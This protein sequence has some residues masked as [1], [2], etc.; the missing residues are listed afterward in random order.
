[1]TSLL[2]YK[3]H[4]IRELIHLI[5]PE[6]CLVCE[7]ELGRSEEHICSFCSQDLERTFFESH[8]DPTP[9]DQLFWGRQKVQ[10]TYAH[11]QF[12]K[13]GGIQR[14]LFNLKY[15]KN[16]QLGVFL[17]ESIGKVIKDNTGKYAFDVLVP[18]PLHPKR[19][20]HRGYN[21]SE[22]LANGISNIASI[23]TDVSLI[24]RRENNR[25][26]TGK[27]RFE[28]WDNVESIFNVNKSVLS[29]YSHIAIVDDVVTTGSTLEA[30]ISEIRSVN[31]DIDISIVTLAIA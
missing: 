19:L 3:F 21:Q 26:Q 23:P 6:T 5:Y 1:M 17:G 2:K 4:F 25:S 29:N 22:L 14:L 8:E 30:I 18:V 10:S 9:M 11:Y 13:G 27:S 28:R 15:G 24:K 20:F 31:P 7:Q 12:K 16:S